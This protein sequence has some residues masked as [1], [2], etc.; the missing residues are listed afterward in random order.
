MLNQKYSVKAVKSSTHAK[1]FL[2]GN[3]IKVKLYSLVLL[4]VTTGGMALSNM[5]IPVLVPPAQSQLGG[6][7]RLVRKSVWKMPREIRIVSGQFL[8][9]F[10]DGVPSYGKAADHIFKVTNRST[11]KSEII[12][13]PYNGSKRFRLPPGEYVYVLKSQSMPGV[14]EGVVSVSP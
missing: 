3:L 4:I 9:I 2:S 5:M 8:E 13:I 6:L 11:G 10:C 12:P 7:A 1:N 14:K